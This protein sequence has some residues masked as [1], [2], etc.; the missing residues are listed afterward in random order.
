MYAWRAEIKL[1]VVINDESYEKH[2]I[3][4]VIQIL[5]GTNN[6]I[7]NKYTNRSSNDGEKKTHSWAHRK[8]GIEIIHL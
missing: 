3:H 7:E 2:A 1:L 6:N 5:N 4:T 8:F